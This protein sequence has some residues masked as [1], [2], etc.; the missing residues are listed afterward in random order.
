MRNQSCM[1]AT[2]TARHHKRQLHEARATTY[3]SK[4]RTREVPYSGTGI[5][6]LT[7]V[8]RLD[9]AEGVYP[10]S[11]GAGV[12]RLYPEPTAAGE[13]H[14]DLVGEEEGA[15]FRRRLVSR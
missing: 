15:D 13:L 14:D 10:V 1:S 6:R 11:E 12:P 7:V 4:C 5:T 3:K 9:A 2:L 8:G